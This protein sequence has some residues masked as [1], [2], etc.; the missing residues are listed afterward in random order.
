MDTRN[1]TRVRAEHLGP[2]RRRPAVLDSAL[3]IAVERGVG[4]VTMV[5]V[6]A[7]A[8]VTRPVTYS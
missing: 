2:E 7:R 3:A 6:A 1:A 5:A 4:A 8:C